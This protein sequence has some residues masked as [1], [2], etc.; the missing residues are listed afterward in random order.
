MSTDPTPTTGPTDLTSMLLAHYPAAYRLAVGL[1]GR[2]DRA[3]VVARRVLD[4]ATVLAPRWTSGEAAERWFL[5]FTVLASRELTGGRSGTEAGLA[6]LA[7]LPGQQREAVVLRHG[8][9]LDLHRVAAAMDCSSA[10]ATNH[11]VMA[12]LALRGAGP[13]E[14]WTAA[15]PDRLSAIV[16]PPAVV[17]GDVARAV[18]RRRW[19]G[20]VRRWAM[21]TALAAGTIVVGWAARQLWRVVVL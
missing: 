11:L 2:A 10:A 20:L 18:A 12:T 8:L 6:W 15:L 21:A 4:R 9:G 16:P 3:A 7:P 13:V 17:S 5:R 14:A 1:C 19:R